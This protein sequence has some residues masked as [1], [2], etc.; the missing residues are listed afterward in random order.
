MSNEWTVSPV[1]V[2]V[3]FKVLFFLIMYRI[4]YSFIQISEKLLQPFMILIY[5]DLNQPRKLQKK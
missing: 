4:L 1:K 3:N 2:C 5:I